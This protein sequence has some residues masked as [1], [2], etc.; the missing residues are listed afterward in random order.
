LKPLE[1][2]SI[3]ATVRPHG[4]GLFGLA[5]SVWAILIWPFQSGDISVKT[6]LYMKNFTFL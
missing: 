5:V 4:T 3:I 2:L 1:V 6:F